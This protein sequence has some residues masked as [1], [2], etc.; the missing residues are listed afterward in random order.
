[1]SDSEDECA[2]PEV[3]K[4][5]K[6]TI[7]PPVVRPKKGVFKTF[8]MEKDV[9]HES[10]SGSSIVSDFQPSSIT[11]PNDSSEEEQ[12]F[13]RNGKILPFWQDDAFEDESWNG[14]K[15]RYMSY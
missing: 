10:D 9:L 3:P 6:K 4:F 15:Q 14:G 7:K 5:S 13:Y 2:P 11:M 8:D 12:V 1:M